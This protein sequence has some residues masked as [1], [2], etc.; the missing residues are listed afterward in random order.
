M[1]QL[2]VAQVEIV[3]SDDNYVC[4]VAEPLEPGFGT[5]VGNSLRR[6][7]LSSLPGAAITSVRIDGI[8]HEF[9]TIPHMKEDTIEF[10]LNVKELRLRALSDRPGTLLLEVSG[11]EGEIT[12]AEIQVPP[13]YEILNP[14][15]HLATLDSAEGEL[16]VEF[17]VEQG[18]G[19]VPAG[20][21]DEL[22]IGVIPV[23][24]IYTPVRKV[25]YRVERTRVGQI[26][27]Y[28]RLVLEAWTDGTMTGVEAMSQS[29]DILLEQLSPFSQLGKPAPPMVE[30]GLGAGTVLTPDRYNTTIEDLSLSVRAYNCLKRSGLMTVGQVLEKSE[31]ELLALR[32]FGR[33]SYD[34]LKTRLRELDF[35][36]DET[37][38]EELPVEVPS[39][40][41]EEGLPAVVGRGREAAAVTA[42]P[43][44][45]LEEPTVVV[46]EAALPKA[47]EV[48]APELAEEAV[49]APTEEEVEAK[50]KPKAK[51]K[52]KAKAKAEEPAVEE[53]EGEE[54]AEWQRMLQKLKDEVGE[55]GEG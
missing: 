52:A 12:A 44:A 3:E 34:E 31:D 23:D 39:V 42:E 14:E 9:S 4:I 35:L 54:M 20:E 13:D 25:N 36:P 28:D 6:V 50:A 16:R 51:P 41:E 29:A 53:E 27:N 30:R 40:I 11:R 7:L 43:A 48:A 55:E 19:Y 49:A 17:N 5:T 45:G 10:L 33:K 18:H 21:S 1:T 37:V 32:N 26:S 15:Q 46:E 22:P 38:E 2:V 24:A 47:A 8:Q